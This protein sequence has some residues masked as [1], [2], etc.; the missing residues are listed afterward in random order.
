MLGFV[1]SWGRWPEKNRASHKASCP[2]LLS[3]AG[4]HRLRLA[5]HELSASA[6]GAALGGEL[7]AVPCQRAPESQLTECACSEESIQASFEHNFESRADQHGSPPVCHYVIHISV[8][9]ATAGRNL[10]RD[11]PDTALPFCLK[12]ML[13]FCCQL[14]FVPGVSTCCLICSAALVRATVLLALA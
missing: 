10:P 3:A 6:L 12:E 14:G 9:R 7:A 5:L 13:L 4:A 11:I 2:T 1:L 8:P